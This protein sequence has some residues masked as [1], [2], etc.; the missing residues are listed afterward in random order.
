M[1]EK[2]SAERKDKEI[3]KNSRGIEIPIN[4]RVEKPLGILKT[5]LLMS[6]AANV[7]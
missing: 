5:S 3:G 4:K 2:I 6:E 7:M 1:F